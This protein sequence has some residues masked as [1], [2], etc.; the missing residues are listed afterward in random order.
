MTTT[1]MKSG[2][3]N[4]SVTRICKHCKK[5]LPIWEFCINGA[6]YFEYQCRNCKALKMREDYHALRE[7]NPER[8]WKKRL[9][10][11]KQNA[12]RRNLEF[13]L[14]IEDLKNCYTRQKGLCWYTGKPMVVDSVDRIDVSRGYSLYNIIMCEYSLNAF[15]NKMNR[16]EFVSLCVSIAKHRGKQI[17][18]PHK[19]MAEKKCGIRWEACNS[20]FGCEFGE[21]CWFDSEDYFYDCGAGSIIS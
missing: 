13:K 18:K 15:R 7:Q 1:T 3:A 2:E 4:I 14:T 6:G 11:L 21:E 10:S 19:T 8:Y 5:E 16:N 17:W 20:R 9:Q 12:T